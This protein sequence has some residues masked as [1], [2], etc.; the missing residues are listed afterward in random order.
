MNSRLRFFIALLAILGAMF[1]WSAIPSS[2]VQRFA[3]AM[4]AGGTACCQIFAG[5]KSGFTI[6]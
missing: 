6:S 4:L 2:F 3:P 1:V 5:K